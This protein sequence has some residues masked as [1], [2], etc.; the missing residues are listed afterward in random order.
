MAQDVLVREQIDG[1][2]EL[3]DRLAAD[4]IEVTA[5]FWAKETESGRWYLFIASPVVDEQ[6]IREAY[7]IVGTAARNLPSQWIDPMEVKLLRSDDVM[8]VA[9]QQLI[10]PNPPPA[11][12]R[13]A[14]YYD[15]WTLGGVGVDG[16]YAYRTSLPAPAA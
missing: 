9:A 14:K 13:S 12:F 6:G 10:A 4:G 3:L 7:G 8:A 5:A 2:R 1:G 15:A 11:T 16:V